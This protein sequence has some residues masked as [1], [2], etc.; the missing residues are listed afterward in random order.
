[1]GCGAGCGVGAGVIGV[2]E[3]LNVVIS[4]VSVAWG[5]PRRSHLGRMLGRP[6]V[7]GDGALGLAGTAAAG[8]VEVD[9]VLA[10]AVELDGIVELDGALV[11]GADCALVAGGGGALVG[12]AGGALVR[13]AVELDCASEGEWSLIR[14]GVSTPDSQNAATLAGPVAALAAPG[15]RDV[16]P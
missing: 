8:A 7:E 6:V 13:G 12:G 5:R 1:M 3:L 9:C 2:V 10:D 11:G 4:V 15:G 16:G 14:G